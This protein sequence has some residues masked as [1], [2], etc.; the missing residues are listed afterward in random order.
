MTF[1]AELRR[2]LRFQQIDDACHGMNRVAPQLRSRAVRRF[3][4]CFQTQPERPFVRRHN[5]QASRFTDDGEVC[6]ETGLD[7]STRA[8]LAGFLNAQ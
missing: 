2:I 6:I 5:L 4:P 8:G 3:A 1:P 7:Q